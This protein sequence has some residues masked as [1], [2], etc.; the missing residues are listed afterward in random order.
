[1][2][3]ITSVIA[4]LNDFEPFFLVQIRPAFVFGHHV[5]TVDGD[6]ELVAQCFGS[7]EKA[8]VPGMEQVEHADDVN[9]F[10]HR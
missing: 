3:R 10:L 7:L 1:M 5:V 2:A 4:V 9:Y 6:D 8:D